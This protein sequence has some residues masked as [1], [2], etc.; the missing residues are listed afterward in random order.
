MGMFDNVYVS[1]D[2]LPITDEERKLIGEDHTFQTKDLDRMLFD[3]TITKEK[4]AEIA[5]FDRDLVEDKNAILGYVFKMKNKRNVSLKDLDS[6][7]FYTMIDDTWIEFNAFFD[8]GKLKNI[9]K[10]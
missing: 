6:L 9:Q 3:V 8:K 2:L 1:N 7:N 5:V 10:I 4:G